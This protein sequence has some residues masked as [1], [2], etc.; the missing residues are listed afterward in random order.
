MG[1]RHFMDALLWLLNNPFSHCH[2]WNLL[3]LIVFAPRD[4]NLVDILLVFICFLVTCRL[5]R[6]VCVS[7]VL[8]QL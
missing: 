5:M 2:D 6:C 1:L 4:Y 7:F 3:A 8:L